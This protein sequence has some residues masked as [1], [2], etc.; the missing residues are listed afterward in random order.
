MIP[1]GHQ[2]IDEEDI[3]AVVNV[4]RSD[5]LTTGPLIEAFEEA[6]ARRVG[7][8]HA[9]AVSSGTAALHA[10]MHALG[11]VQ[12]D[13]V[14]VPA[15]TF[16]ASANC[17]VYQGGTPV[18]ADVDPET[19]LIDPASV[20]SRLSSKTKAII[21]VDFAGQPCDYDA[22]KDIAERH[23]LVLVADACHALGGRYKDKPVGT[24]AALNAF[25]FHPVKHITTGEG[26]MITTD[27]PIMAER[28]LL[29]RNHGITIDH[30]QRAQQGSWFYEMVELGYNYRITDFQCALGM[31]QLKKLPKWVEQRREIA[32]FYDNAFFKIP[33][34]KPLG[35]NG[36]VL[37][38]YH[39]YV[40]RLI[41]DGTDLSRE[42]IF[43]TL[44]ESGI[45]ANVHYMP[46]HLHPY[47]RNKFMTTAGLCPVA[48]DAY[49]KIISLPIFQGLSFDKVDYVIECV[50]SLFKTHV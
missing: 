33:F 25:S 24:L 18:F 40:I 14:I 10:A 9:V 29:F 5:W 11:L 7:A 44:R 37:H 23:N 43:H 45:G 28:M 34:V 38:A 4:L 42:E 46:V 41:L 39:L 3:Q 30:R 8:R 12:G 2:C 17:V 1:Y 35:V 49:T 50:K 15:I 27:D 47:Y 48:E 26:G 16:A 6:F 31:S 22:L 21:A 20:E 13:E 19:L 36:D 32:R